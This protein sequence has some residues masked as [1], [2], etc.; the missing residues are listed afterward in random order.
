MATHPSTQGGPD[1]PSWGARWSD[2]DRALEMGSDNSDSAKAK[3]S[4][5][6]DNRQRLR[7]DRW[8]SSVPTD[9]GSTLETS[10]RALQAGTGTRDRSVNCWAADSLR[11][12]AQ[13]SG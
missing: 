3:G 4:N 13:L 6:Q 8:C 7:E 9:H 1:R 10:P 12:Y 5:P 11:H 2:R